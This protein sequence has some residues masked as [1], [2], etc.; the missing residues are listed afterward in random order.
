MG[1]YL[2]RVHLM[3]VHLTGVPLMGVHFA[4]PASPA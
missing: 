4:A 2:T 1:V 3:G